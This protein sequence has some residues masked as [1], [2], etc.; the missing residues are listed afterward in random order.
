MSSYLSPQFKYMIFHIFICTRRFLSTIITTPT[1]QSS[2]S[3]TRKEYSRFGVVV[4][5]YRIGQLLETLAAMETNSEE[6]TTED[7][8]S[9]G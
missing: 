9:L 4:V 7:E 5:F 6:K 3:L 2:H 1:A 8:Y